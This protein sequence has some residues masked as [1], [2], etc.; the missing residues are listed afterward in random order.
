MLLKSKKVAEK[1]FRSL[2]LKGLSKI[3]KFKNQIVQ[4]FMFQDTPTLED[5]LNPGTKRK[6]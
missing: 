1:H 2:N 3:R 6:S 4:S 5:R